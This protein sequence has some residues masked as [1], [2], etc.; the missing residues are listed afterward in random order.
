MW[1]KLTI[2][3]PT[4]NNWQLTLRTLKSVGQIN[5]PKSQLEIIIIDNNSKDNTAKNIKKLFPNII[6]LSQKSNLGFAKAINIASKAAT[7]EYLFI[8][9]NDVSFKKTYLARLLSFAI[10]TPKL[11]VC[12]GKI[13]TESLNGKYFDGAVN[14]SHSTS[15]LKRLENY[16][17][18][19]EVD[20]IS[21]A[22][23]LVKK[24]IF[25]KVKGFDTKF[26]FYFEDLDFCFRVKKLGYQIIYFPQATMYH[27]QSSTASTMP[28]KWQNDVWIQGKMLV[29][30]KH[31]RFWVIPFIILLKSLFY[32]YILVKRRQNRF[33]SLLRAITKV[34]LA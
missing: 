3:F 5:Y 9:N 7:G 11:G 20:Y 32:L 19:Q 25:E 2:I 23:M 34:F 8:T 33:G 14:V 13:V 1:P 4:Y 29:I 30:K 22:G 16:H 15:G 26:Q 10:N 6:L 27:K 31:F 21:G 18:T 12:G 17:K 24:D 28:L